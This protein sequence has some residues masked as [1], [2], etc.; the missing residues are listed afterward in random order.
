MKGLLQIDSAVIAVRELAVAYS[1][2][3]PSGWTATWTPSGWTVT[4]T[5]DFPCMYTL[6]IIDLI[7]S[8]N[9]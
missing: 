1:D 5:G 3:L 6:Y 8:G 2:E 4:G 7:N 9:A